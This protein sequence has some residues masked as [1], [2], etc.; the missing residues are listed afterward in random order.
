M[1][2]LQWYRRATS[3]ALHMRSCSADAARIVWKGQKAFKEVQVFTRIVM[4]R[5][6]PNSAQQFSQTIEKKVLPILRNQKGFRDEVTLIASNEQEAIGL[7]FWDSREQAEAYSNS[8]YA[9]VQ[10]ELN[11]LIDG[12]PRV[13]TY[14]V[15]NSTAHKIA[16][17]SAA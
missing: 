9:E 17:Q 3:L 16:A 12:A 1:L 14:D 8:K 7:S 2:D 6:K 5:L 15:A 10:R 11:H 13:Q 4:V